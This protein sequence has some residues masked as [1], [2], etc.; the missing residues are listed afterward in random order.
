MVGNHASGSRGSAR[1]T[2]R[3]ESFAKDCKRTARDDEQDREA[4]A[5]ARLLDEII[6]VV[7]YFLQIQNDLECLLE[8]L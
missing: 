6:S 3:V 2:W 8:L 5:I 4:R 7:F 1:G